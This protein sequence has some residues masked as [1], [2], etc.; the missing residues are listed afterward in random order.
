MSFLRGAPPPKKNPGSAPGSF[1]LY[2]INRL[3]L[4]VFII[5][6]VMK[7]CHHGHLEGKKE[8]AKL[9]LLRSALLV[10]LISMAIIKHGVNDYVLTNK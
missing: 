1:H 5:I 8:F 6:V 3:L 2:L 9:L 10:T 7:S 4:Q